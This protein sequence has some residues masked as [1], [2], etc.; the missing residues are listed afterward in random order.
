MTIYEILLTHLDWSK[1]ASDG[2]FLAVGLVAM[3]ILMW[4]IW[5]DL[6]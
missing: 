1:D 6:R 3:G 5:R 4:T 2:A